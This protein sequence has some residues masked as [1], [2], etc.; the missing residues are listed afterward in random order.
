MVPSLGFGLI[1]VEIMSGVKLKY[2][3]ELWC[4]MRFLLK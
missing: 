2:L 1:Y 3:L 4:L